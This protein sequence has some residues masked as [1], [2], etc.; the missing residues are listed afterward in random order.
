V[1]KLEIGFNTMFGSRERWEERLKKERKLTNQNLSIV[2][3][4][5]KCKRMEESLWVPSQIC[6]RPRM[7]RK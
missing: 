2:W 5:L 6:F 7:E 3:I 1:A 4:S